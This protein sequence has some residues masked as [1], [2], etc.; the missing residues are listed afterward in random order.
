MNDNFVKFAPSWISFINSP[1]SQYKGDDYEILIKPLRS[2]ENSTISIIMISCYDGNPTDLLFLKTYDALK[3]LTATTQECCEQY[4]TSPGG[5][6]LQTSSCMATITKTIQ[7]RRTRHA[8]HCW[9]SR[10]ELASDIFLWTPSHGRVKAGRPARTYIQQLCAYTGCSPEDLPEAID[11][12]EGWRER[13]RIFVLIARHDDD[14]EINLFKKIWFQH[15]F[16]RSRM[17]EKFLVKEKRKT[18]PW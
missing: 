12:R 8:G 11:D 13:V 10:D 14:D 2:F 15:F 9:R 4:W 17:R 18:F 16:S 5:S 3:S 1:N 6:T 7:V